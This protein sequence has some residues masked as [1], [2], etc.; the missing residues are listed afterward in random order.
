MAWHTQ[1]LRD[2]K[3]PSVPLTRLPLGEIL[4]ILVRGA[5]LPPRPGTRP[6]VALVPLLLGL[7]PD[8]NVPKVAREPSRD[9]YLLY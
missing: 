7:S 9:C 4:G 5:H 8:G 3:R 1:T 2:Q 6:F